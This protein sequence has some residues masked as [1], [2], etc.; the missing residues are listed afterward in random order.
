VVNHVLAPD[1]TPAGDLAG[2]KD[3]SRAPPRSLPASAHVRGLVADAISCAP[4]EPL[5]GRL[6]DAWE[7]RFRRDFSGVRIHSDRASA[8]SARGLSALAY[9]IGRHV[10]IDPDR[11]RPGT[12]AWSAVLAHEL[13]HVTQQ[14]A[15][16]HIPVD[17]LRFAG[18]HEERQARRAGAAARA[19]GPMPVL[20][21]G[22]PAIALADDPGPP[23]PPTQIPTGRRVVIQW[24]DDPVTVANAQALSASRLVHFQDLAREDLSEAREL[25]VVIHGEPGASDLEGNRFIREGEAAPRADFGRV[26]TR[27]PSSPD[28][29]PVTVTPAEMA[30]VLTS[31]GFGKGR[32]TRYRVRLVMCFGGVGKENSFATR[33]SAE[34][35]ARHVQTEV[36]GATGRVSA[37]AG[38]RTEPVPRGQGE[39]RASARPRAGTPQVEK[40]Y[41][42]K[43]FDPLFRRPGSGWQRVQVPAPKGGVTGQPPAS[44]SPPA[45][46]PPTV[47]AGSGDVAP[48]TPAVKP[49]AR[50][51]LPEGQQPAAPGAGPP[52]AGLKPRAPSASRA[53]SMVAEAAVG[54]AIALGTGL[55]L[56]YLE[57]LAQHDQMLAEYDAVMRPKVAARLTELMPDVKAR[58][59]RNPGAPVFVTLHYQMKGW[60][61]YTFSPVAPGPPEYYRPFWRAHF[62]S[63]DM[64]DADMTR[65]ETYDEREVVRWGP[66]ITYMTYDY[67]LSW[68]AATGLHGQSADDEA[69]DGAAEPGQPSAGKGPARAHQ[70]AQAVRP[71]PPAARGFPSEEEQK[72]SHP[73][74]TSDRPKS[75]ADLPGGQVTDEELRRLREWAEAHQG[76]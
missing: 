8:E 40:H 57:K 9:A 25:D 15:S 67:L 60:T 36:L 41:L 1:R 45:V 65:P 22:S 16:E 49:P 56:M 12:P 76:K 70:P 33:L 44:S 58:F 73:H 20:D 21:G 55:A 32:W 23:R 48:P 6:R 61:T 46:K 52:T 17:R 31:A 66:T 28:T 54:G 59:A 43:P 37:V 42:E 27:E 72:G 11:T 14:R 5:D 24:G 39:P 7:P 26:G 75:L 30:G 29:P 64:T 68:D 10:V 4:G 53:S 50:T 19:D 74:G 38:L 51:A 34:M 3:G 18:E 13:A 47:A 71:S 35:S 69:P 63:L 2:E 62:L